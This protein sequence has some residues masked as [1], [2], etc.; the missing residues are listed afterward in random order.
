VEALAC[1]WG[2]IREAGINQVWFELVTAAIP[3][4]TANGGSPGARGV[5]AI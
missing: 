2:I 1:R 4:G 3:I 5:K